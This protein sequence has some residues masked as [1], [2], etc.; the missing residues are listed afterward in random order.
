MKR[1]LPILMVAVLTSLAIL[2]F[3][4]INV[5][6]VYKFVRF[7]LYAA[8]IALSFLAAGWL[9]GRLRLAAATVPIQHKTTLTLSDLLTRRELQVL[10]LIAAGKTNK[11][12]AAMHYIEL[13]TV[14][15]HV[16]NIY[17]KLSVCNRREAR[18][19]FYSSGEI[20]NNL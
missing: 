1:Y 6:V 17:G 10:Q 14:K 18:I 12:I 5:L 3:Q 19:R 16:N 7:D 13:S 2:L 11:E 4:C 20:I 15:T 8:I 9:I